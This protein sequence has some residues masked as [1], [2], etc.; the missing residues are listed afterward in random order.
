MA[1]AALAA[2]GENIVAASTLSE[3]T[4]LQFKYRLRLL[5]IIVKFVDV[6]NI[7][8]VRDAVDEKTRAIYT[9]SISS[10]GLNIADLSELADIAHEAGIPL[11]V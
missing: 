1:I 4:Y 2:A 5:G 3:E 10:I 11:V 8:S 9:E 6:D 7:S